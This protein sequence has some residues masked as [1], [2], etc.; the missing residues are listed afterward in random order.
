VRAVDAQGIPI[1]GVRVT[2][3]GM[4][5][6]TDGQ[7]LIRITTYEDSRFSGT[8]ESTG[9]RTREVAELAD[10]MDVV[11]EPVKTFRVRI[12][13]LP[14]DLP[15]KRIEV[16]VRHEQRERFL[17]P[18]GTPDDKGVTE[19]TMPQPGRYKVELWVKYAARG[20]AMTLVAIRPEP[21]TI[22]DD[23]APDVQWQLDA[24]SVQRLR[25]RLR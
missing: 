18:R 7:G 19:L 20:E 17:G 14:D 16:W 10:G 1:A 11:L 23:G 8:F 6:T 2:L 5:L 13:G 3:P 22:G 15:R 24:E 21:V 9:L 25:E 4:I 12:L